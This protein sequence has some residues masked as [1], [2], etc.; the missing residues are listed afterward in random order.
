MQFLSS[1]NEKRAGACDVSRST[2]LKDN[3]ETYAQ[4]SDFERDRRRITLRSSERRVLRQILAWG[5][6][7]ALHPRT[8]GDCCQW[9]AANSRAGGDRDTGRAD[10][11]GDGVKDSSEAADDGDSTCISLPANWTSS[12]GENTSHTSLCVMWVGK[13]TWT[14]YF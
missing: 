11:E 5:P 12:S 14:M 1:P 13:E 7:P 2:C 10:T 8:C 4:I 3:R 9:K 6:T